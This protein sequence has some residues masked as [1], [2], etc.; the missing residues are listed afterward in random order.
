M[1]RQEKAPRIHSEY[2]RL[3]HR[4][5]LQI[6]AVAVMG[7]AL[8]L[9]MLGGRF[10]TFTRR[11]AVVLSVWEI[12]LFLVLTAVSVWM[13]RNLFIQADGLY[14]RLANQNGEEPVGPAEIAARRV[15]DLIAIIE[16]I[17]GNQPFRQTLDFIYRSFS[18]YIPYTHIGVAL[19][20][21]DARLIRATYGVSADRHARLARRL[22]GY[23]A[24]L[25][26]TSLGKVIE[27]GEPRVI[28]D[29]EDYLKD[30]K[31]VH[32]YNQILLEEGIRSSIAFPLL[33]N[34]AAVGIIFFSSDRK[35]VYGPEH[36]DFLKVL[37]NSI[38]LSLEKTIMI[39]DMVVSSTLALAALAEERDN[40]TGDHLVRM[41]NYSRMVAELLAG[42]HRYAGSVDLDYVNAIERF[43]PLHDIGKVAIRDNILLKP[44]RLTP[45]EFEVMKTHTTYGAR[46]LRMANE[47][48]K[49]Q[50]RDVFRIG[51]EIAESH[52]E[53]WDGTGYPY[54]KRGREIPLSA[55]I[56]A[57]AD[58]FDALTSRRVYKPAYSFEK[59]VEILT[60]ESGTHFDPD[61]VAVLLQ[62]QEKLRT[63]YENSWDSIPNTV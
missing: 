36:I 46:V 50:G 22:L 18:P 51:V 59:S 56:V 21:R 12:L 40:D 24:P 16:N 27:G 61:I 9:S 17:E 43:S 48:L 39:D 54:G 31:P 57:V 6:A 3:Y 8:L 30:R 32:R 34:N 41:R 5:K 10:L 15:G 19:L 23:T 7:A 38:M 4:R 13:Y 52:H 63:C 28:N 62:N 55:R 58:V 42:D 60:G 2:P 53:H 14:H 49:K 11:Q 20:D 33:N 1:N 26:K 29:L 45:E 35:N 47:N 25:D 37:A 44:G